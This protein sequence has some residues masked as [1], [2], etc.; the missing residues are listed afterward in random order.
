MSN[1]SSQ[2]NTFVDSNDCCTEEF[3]R[4]DEGMTQ[5]REHTILCACTKTLQMGACCCVFSQLECQYLKSTEFLQCNACHFK[6]PAEVGLADED[7]PTGERLV[8][9]L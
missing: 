3:K 4:A 2:K 6:L 8:K 5:I 1:R 9:Y 7:G